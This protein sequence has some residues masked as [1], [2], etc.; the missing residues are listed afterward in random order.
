MA[1]GVGEVKRPIPHIGIP[2][3]ALGVGGVGD[4]GVGADEA[5]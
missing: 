3:I 2:V 4:E 5:V 1:C